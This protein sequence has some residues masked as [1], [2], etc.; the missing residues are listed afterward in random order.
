MFKTETHLHTSEVSP[1]SRIRAV[2]MI[3]LYYEA[4]Y[5]TVFITDHFQANTIDALG[6][7]PWCEKTA[8]FLAGYYKAKHAG[9]ALGVN[10]IMGAEFRFLDAPNHYLAYGIS[11]EFLDR[12]PDI[13]KITV[14]QFR[15]IAVENGIF[16]IQA[17]PYRDGSCYPTPDLVD[18]IEVYNSNPRHADYSDMSEKLAREKRLPVIA[19]SDSHRPEDVCL[20][21]I[22]TETE[23]KTADDFIRLVKSGNIEVIRSNVETEV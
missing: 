14:E 13:H 16:V 17:H 5:K 20:C 21:G 18:G 9:D 7:I 2:E 6:D 3:R 8:I 12:Y 23:I 22:L 1:C 11:K 4:G 15:K 19:G 10:V